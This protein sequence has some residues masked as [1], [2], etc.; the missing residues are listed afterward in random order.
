MIRLNSVYLQLFI[1]PVGMCVRV[2]VLRGEGGRNTV[3]LWV[4]VSGCVH[5]LPDVCGGQKTTCRSLF[6]PSTMSEGPSDRSQATRHCANTFTCLAT[7]PTRYSFTT[8]K[9]V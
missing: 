2:C 3:C 9:N 7:S 4:D 1:Y 8:Y 6:S 5:V